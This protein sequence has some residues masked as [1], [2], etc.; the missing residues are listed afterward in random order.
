M[1]SFRTFLHLLS[2][3]TKDLGS[4]L[5]V[6]A[7]LVHIADSPVPLSSFFFYLLIHPARPRDKAQSANAFLAR[8]LCSPCLPQKLQLQAGQRL[9]VRPIVQA[10]RAWCSQKHRKN[11]RS[12]ACHQP[13][14]R[15]TRTPCNSMQENIQFYV[16]EHAATLVL[17]TV[18]VSHPDTFIDPT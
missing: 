11:M 15:S 5:R 8:R 4:H 10:P 16:S 17:A 1:V 6:S 3:S 7:P 14:N 13:V 18:L 12:L 9:C 2:N